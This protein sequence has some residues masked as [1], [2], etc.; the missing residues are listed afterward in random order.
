LSDNKNLMNRTFK[1]ILPALTAAGMLFSGCQE[2]DTT[3]VAPASAR[4][5]FV[6]AAPTVSANV[7]VYTS[8]VVI[9][10]G[11]NRKANLSFGNAAATN[12]TAGKR[13]VRIRVAEATEDALRSELSLEGYA[14][15]TALIINTD[16]TNNSDSA[17]V[18]VAL[19]KDDLTPPSAGNAKVRFVHLGIG[20]PAIDVYAFVT[21]TGVTTPAMPT[22]ANKSFGQL[23]PGNGMLNLAAG[24]FGAVTEAPFA[25]VPAGNYRFEV[26]RA[27]TASTTTALL[28]ATS[29]LAAGRTYTILARGFL[30]A[31]AGV[32]GRNLGVQVITHDLTVY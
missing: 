15:Y 14:H 30:Q 13:P 23:G 10:G 1:H 21:G 11:N 4:M 3:K 17:P 2:E 32:S 31:P 25:E 5:L 26:R 19:L 18:G 9:Y 28:S 20:A 24:D 22:F 7:E 6:H 29:P 27:G 12:P 8:D 16:P